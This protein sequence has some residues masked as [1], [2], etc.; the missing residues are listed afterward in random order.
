[1]ALMSDAPA[2][3]ERRALREWVKSTK[4]DVRFL[5][6][7]LCTTVIRPDAEADHRRQVR[8][9][10]DAVKG[11]SST[12]A[13]ATAGLFVATAPSLDAASTATR[14]L[15]H[16]LRSLVFEDEDEL[17]A[18]VK[19]GARSGPVGAS[20]PRA[21]KMTLEARSAATSDLRRRNRGRF[22]KGVMVGSSDGAPEAEEAV[23]RRAD[24][25]AVDFRAV[26]DLMSLRDDAVVSLI[27][28]VLERFERL[29]SV[30]GLETLRSERSEG[31][32]RMR[33]LRGSASLVSVKLATL[34]EVF[35]SL[36]SVMSR[37]RLIEEGRATAATILNLEEELEATRA[38][39]TEKEA[40]C[41]LLNQ[42]VE[43]LRSSR[44]GGVT[45]Q[46]L[47]I[48]AQLTRIQQA[49]AAMRSQDLEVE[50]LLKEVNEYR[51]STIELARQLELLRGRV[52]STQASLA[53]RVA[54]AERRTKD[55]L[56]AVQDLRQSLDLLA[57]MYQ[58]LCDQLVSKN[59]QLSSLE[60]ERNSLA[61]KLHT[62]VR[63]VRVL[64]S[65]VARM[66]AV[67]VRIMSAYDSMRA[68]YRETATA[69]EEGASDSVGRAT[70]RLAV[71][72]QSISRD[73]IA[74]IGRLHTADE[75][76][77]TAVQALKRIV[78]VCDSAR[79]RGVR[80]DDGAFSASPRGSLA[81]D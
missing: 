25:S 19:E 43:T 3:L 27:N 55:A 48:D 8:S 7:Y 52:G 80:G 47:E 73:A 28:K 4:A 66:D 15:E 71:G 57:G 36:D 68:A 23:E 81:G 58:R 65:E 34:L 61:K 67:N 77:E 41:V 45:T 70:K 13:V 18:A 12:S 64:E 14:E 59:E 26:R 75:V 78:G 74:R 56:N 2:E 31:V 29:N 69:A 50:G 35:D 16:K 38:S 60:S 42:R 51:E 63:K 6:E 10:L 11:A 79:G 22:R 21:A 17:L 33:R 53:P 37:V 76:S 24:E 1:M 9:A 49:K 5:N 54:E 30:I 39:L 32:S 46:A 20:S 40:E 62:E 72:I 44:S